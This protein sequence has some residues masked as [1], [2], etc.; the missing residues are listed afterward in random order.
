[1]LFFFDCLGKEIGIEDAVVCFS[2]TESSYETPIE[3]G[4]YFTFTNNGYVVFETISKKVIVEIIYDM[5]R[6]ECL[7][8]RS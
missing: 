3:S 4:K 5:D 2:T 6:R 7:L 1:M 8:A